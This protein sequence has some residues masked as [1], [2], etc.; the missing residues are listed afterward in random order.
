MP[1][2]ESLINAHSEAVDLSLVHKLQLQPRE[3]PPEHTGE[4]LAILDLLA[5]DENG[6]MI[7]VEV[8][9]T[10]KPVISLNFLEYEITREGRW[11]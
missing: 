10:R 8:Q 2:L 9:T 3:L 11:L 5:E 7:N 6:R 4:K 1:L